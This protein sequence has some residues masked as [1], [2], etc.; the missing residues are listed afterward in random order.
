MVHTFASA[1]IDTNEDEVLHTYYT[2]TLH[3]D[4][5]DLEIATRHF[6]HDFDSDEVKISLTGRW[7]SLNTNLDNEAIIVLDEDNS[8]RNSL[9]CVVNG[10]LETPTSITSEGYPFFGKIV[11]FKIV[12]KL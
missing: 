10:G 8:K 9:V 4:T 12:S 5:Y 1:H 7:S 6:A 3:K 2:L 11:D